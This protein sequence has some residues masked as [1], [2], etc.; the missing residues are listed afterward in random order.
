[1]SILY[2]IFA[3]FSLIVAFF[4]VLPFLMVLFSRLTGEK[5]KTIKEEDPNYKAYDYG[6]IITAYKNAEIAKPLI[7]SLLRQKHKKHHIYLVADECD[8]TGWDLE[9]ERLMV[10]NP[11]PS[12]RLKAKS[13]IQTIII[14]SLTS[15]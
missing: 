3:I 13:I 15:R 6:C 2:T 8:I 5:I 10:L 1:M 14:E 11:K 4:L 12:L 9:D 7:Q